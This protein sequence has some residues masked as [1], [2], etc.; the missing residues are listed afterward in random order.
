MIAF[1]NTI[2]FRPIFNILILLYEMIPGRDFGVA[3]IV[4]TIIIRF[5]FS[6][7]SIKVLRSQRELTKLQ[8]EIKEINR[9]FK[10][11]KQAAAKATMDLY[12]AHKVNPFAGCLPL[13]IQIPILLAL[14]SAFRSGLNPAGVSGLY[15]FISHPG[16]INNTFLGFINLTAH[17]PI[18][19][20]LAGAMQW[21]QSR[22]AA[23]NMIHPTQTGANKDSQ[24]MTASVMNKQMLY[25]L[26]IMIIIIAW[27]LPAGLVVYWVVTTIYSIFEQ[28]YINKKY[29]IN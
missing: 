29:P 27:S 2:L 18:M 7:L 5:I 9:K 3:I 12:K 15:S 26:P 1:F 13:L 19:A 10:D 21:I 17:N 4:L 28:L 14:Y 20:V 16:V 6:P 24:D 25:F 23:K 8:P 11:D 22:L